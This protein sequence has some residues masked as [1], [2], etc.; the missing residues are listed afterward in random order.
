MRQRSRRVLPLAAT[1][2]SP[3]D[4]AVGPPVKRSRIPVVLSGVAALGLL[5]VAYLMTVAVAVPGE[6]DSPIAHL[7]R[8]VG[9]VH[10]FFGLLGFIASSLLYLNASNARVWGLTIL[11]LGLASI[12]SLLL[13]VASGTAGVL[14]LALPGLLALVAGYMGASQ[15]R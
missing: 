4:A 13:I 2:P 10:Y 14:V 12:I 7:F 8:E 6:I 3:S 15:T 1:A 9:S 5:A 11:G